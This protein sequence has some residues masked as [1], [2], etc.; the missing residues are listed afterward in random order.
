MWW[1][2]NISGWKTMDSSLSTIQIDL[3]LTSC[4]SATDRGVSRPAALTV[5][6]SLA[7][8]TGRFVGIVRLSSSG[9]R[10]WYFHEGGIDYQ[11]LEG[12]HGWLWLNGED[13]G[14]DGSWPV[15]PIWV[16]FARTGSS[17]SSAEKVCGGTFDRWFRVEDHHMLIMEPITPPRNMCPG[18]N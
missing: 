10:L 1:L 14:P 18:V 15:C 3:S 6:A 2:G 16:G 7:W 12:F 8:S 13:D 5:P 11:R 17:G 4:F 9:G